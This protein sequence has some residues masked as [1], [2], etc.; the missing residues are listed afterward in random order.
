VIARKASFKEETVSCPDG[1]KNSPGSFFAPRECA[2]CKLLK[3]EKTSI[4]GINIHFC[5]NLDCNS[6]SSARLVSVIDGDT[7][8][9]EIPQKETVRLLGIDA[10]EKSPGDHANT[11]CASLGIDCETLKVLA[12]LSQIHLGGLCPIGSNVTIKTTGRLR[13]DYSRVLAGIYL[14]DRCINR[15]MVED[16]YALAYRGVSDWESYESLEESS[17]AAGRGIW[18]SCEEPFYAATTKS[19][20]RP[21]CFYARN[22]TTRL[23]SRDAARGAGLSPCSACLPDYRL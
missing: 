12:R 6:T 13:D 16:G 23:P 22:T 2:G 19:Y 17:K 8:L 15:A 1:F 4:R 3:T 9:V 7:V 11:Q 21:G 5:Q 10:P 20:H 14:Q 18:G